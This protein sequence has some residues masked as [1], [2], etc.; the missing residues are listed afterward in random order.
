[1]IDYIKRMNDE[2]WTIK[3]TPHGREVISEGKMP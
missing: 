1:M 3:G 2:G